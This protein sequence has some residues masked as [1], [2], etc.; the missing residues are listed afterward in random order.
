MQEQ[1]S[2]QVTPDVSPVQKVNKNRQANLAAMDLLREQYPEVFSKESP[3]PLKIGI[4]EDLVADEKVSKNKIKRALATYVRSYQYL[5]SF[6]EGA[7]RVD[8]Q[9]KPAGKVT[10]D[11]AAYAAGKL[12]V[13]QDARKARIK[14]QQKEKKLQEK[15]Q[16]ITSKLDQLLS[17]HN[18]H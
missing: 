12:Q 14:E 9:G 2:Q 18:K 11:E 13:M 4:Q 6:V 1:T 15:E 17:L 8:L 10:A 16:R 7:D 3:R 5:K